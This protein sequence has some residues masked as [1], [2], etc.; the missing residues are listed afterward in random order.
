M[1][2]DLTLTAHQSWQGGFAP[3]ASE[4][5]KLRVKSTKTLQGYSS[6]YHESAITTD[7]FQFLMGARD[8]GDG[9][10]TLP[11]HAPKGS[12]YEEWIRRPVNGTVRGWLLDIA[13]GFRTDTAETIL[14]A[15][16]GQAAWHA[17]GT[18]AQS[19]EGQEAAHNLLRD[20]IMTLAQ[21]DPGHEVGLTAESVL[22]IL[23]SMTVTSMAPGELARTLPGGTSR[24]KGGESA[25]KRWE[26]RRNEAKLRVEELYKCLGT[27]TERDFVHAHAS[28]F[29][30]STIG[31]GK[32][33]REMPDGRSTSPPR[34]KKLDPQAQGEVAGGSYKSL[35]RPK[36]AVLSTPDSLVERALWITEPFRAQRRPR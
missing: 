8:K 34:S 36:K 11:D 32:P 29:L 4:D 10:L 1:A 2:R 14:S 5:K 30:K 18:K 33:G 22:V 25:R 12:Y 13:D 19:L 6:G 23:A 17:S 15:P 3:D 31:S 35:S 27:K 9:T 20:K 24:V 26:A 28:D 7:T 21:A 16:S